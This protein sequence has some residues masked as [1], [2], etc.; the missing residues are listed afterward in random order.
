MSDPA[1]VAVAFQRDPAMKALAKLDTMVTVVD[2]ASFGENFASVV[3]RVRGVCVVYR[4]ASVHEH[5]H[6][7]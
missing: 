7:K 5:G 4:S 6:A 1:E 2:T 3:C